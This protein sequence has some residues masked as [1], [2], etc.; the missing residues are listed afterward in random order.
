MLC[1]SVAAFNEVYS[2]RILRSQVIAGRAYFF[3][4]GSGQL[5]LE[6][7]CFDGA[8]R[9]RQRR[10]V[11]SDQ[12][13]GQMSLQDSSMQLDALQP[14][15]QFV[16]LRHEKIDHKNSAID[17]I[18]EMNTQK[19]RRQAVSAVS[20]NNS[21][22][23]VVSQ[24]MIANFTIA[25][26]PP[27][28][29]FSVD[30]CLSTQDTAL[31]YEDTEY[32]DNRCGF[33]GELVNFRWTSGSSYRFAMGVKFSDPL[34]EGVINV[35]VICP[36]GTVSAIQLS[37]LEASQQRVT[38]GET[39][40]WSFTAISSGT[41]AFDTCSSRGDTVTT[42]DT[43]VTHNNR[44]GLNE[45]VSWNLTSGETI[46]VGA[47]FV[48]STRSGYIVM[49]V[50]CPMVSQVTRSRTVSCG[51]TLSDVFIARGDTANVSFVPFM[52]GRFVFRTCDSSTGVDTV[53][54]FN[55]RRYDDDMCFNNEMLEQPMTAR[56][57]Y[58]VGV[59]FANTAFSGMAAVSLLCFN[60]SGTTLT[61]SA[62]VGT[63]TWP[64][65]R[66]PTIPSGGS[67]GVALQCGQTRRVEIT[68]AGECSCSN[69][70]LC[71]QGCDCY[72]QVKGAHRVF[73]PSTFHMDGVE[74]S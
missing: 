58:F 27:R 66:L 5:S 31:L 46:T 61:T 7:I 3:S 21:T 34:S 40:T 38:A 60:V 23:L 19:R 55:S 14:A 39:A 49:N 13:I 57:R 51:S 72:T 17:G 25:I 62:P 18:A 35:R 16:V 15:E 56:R 22:S 42:I 29:N 63:P 43:L 37:C 36:G 44:C 59:R 69:R 9:Q 6:V 20:C 45:R 2:T 24:G 4:F 28:G 64:P 68:T 47:R 74:F 32:N 26:T 70:C 30:T 10:K 12:S 8:V 1:L 50:V 54:V 71:P 73:D 41:Y 67:G 11:T 48:A 53:L 52:S 33:D 65:T